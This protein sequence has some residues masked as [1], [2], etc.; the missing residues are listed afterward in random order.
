MR[1]RVTMTDS[2]QSPKSLAEVVAAA[3]RLEA[4]PATELAASVAFAR[5]V[6]IE[7]IEPYLK[8]ALLASGV[9]PTVTFGGYDLVRQDVSSPDS[10]LS[11]AK[12]AVVVLAL[13]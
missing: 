9:R 10:V 2:N 11:K 4:G 12:A 1:H 6:T 8:Y 7:G 5:N 3:S 13:A